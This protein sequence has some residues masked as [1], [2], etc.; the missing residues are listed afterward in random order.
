MAFFLQ[1]I[2]SCFRSRM[3]HNSFHCEAL[4]FTRSWGKGTHCI[5][6]PQGQNIS[7]NYLILSLYSRHQPSSD[8]LPT[9][10][11]SEYLQS[12]CKIQ[13]AGLFEAMYHCMSKGSKCMMQLHLVLLETLR[14]HEVMIQPCEKADSTAGCSKKIKCTPSTSTVSR[15]G[16]QIISKEPQ[17]FQGRSNTFSSVQVKIWVT[18]VSWATDSD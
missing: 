5:P 11:N 14:N 16:N 15:K 9:N 17:T 8:L 1:V 13:Q 12:V 7:L 2:S 3:A 10:L 18:H 6:L 4:L